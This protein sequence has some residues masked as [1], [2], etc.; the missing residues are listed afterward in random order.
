MTVEAL[1]S[2]EMSNGRGLNQSAT[3]KRSGDT[4]WGSHYDALISL[5]HMFPPVIDVLE[6]IV[7][8]KSN[9]GQRCEANNLLE[10]M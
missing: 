4:H 10:V 5:I 8:D 9:Y 2:D 3:L 1:K 7:D 6:K